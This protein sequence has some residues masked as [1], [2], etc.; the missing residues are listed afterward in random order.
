MEDAKALLAHG[1]DGLVF[2]FLHQDGSL[3][4]ERTR[5]LTELARSAGKAAV[6]HRAIDVAP[7]W[8]EAL[9]ALAG[10]RLPAY[11]PADRP[12]TCPRLRTPSG[13]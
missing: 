6:F 1:A 9:D 11:S 8:R 4:L 10:Q 3:D 12:P 5:I 13:R 2:G 7:D